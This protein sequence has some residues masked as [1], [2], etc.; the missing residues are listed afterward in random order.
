MGRGCRADGICAD[1][2]H[3]GHILVIVARLQGTAYYGAVVIERNTLYLMV[4]VVDFKTRCG[5]YANLAEARSDLHRVVVVA[6]D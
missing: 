4:F 5:L 1:V 3:A 2:T 6:T